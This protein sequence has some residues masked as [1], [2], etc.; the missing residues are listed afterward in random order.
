MHP[1]I[2]WKPSRLVQYRHN[3]CKKCT[4]DDTV[5]E[6][7]HDAFSFSLVI[8]FLGCDKKNTYHYE[9]RGRH[10]KRWKKVDAIELKHCKKQRT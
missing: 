4:F 9:I 2:G 6:D 10:R 1:V 3:P 5:E 8:G 7:N